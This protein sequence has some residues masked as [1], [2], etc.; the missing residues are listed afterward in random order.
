MKKL[1]LAALA[2]TLGFASCSKDS[3]GDQPKGDEYASVAFTFTNSMTRGGFDQIDPGEAENGVN[4]SILAITGR[5]HVFI[6]KQGN[7]LVKESLDLSNASDFNSN[8]TRPFTHKTGGSTDADRLKNDIDQVILVGNAPSGFAAAYA[9]ATTV[10][11]L[12]AIV[13]ELSAA[14]TSYEGQSMWV[15]GET[16]TINE[17]STS[18]NGNVT[19]TNMEASINLH[20]VLSRL[21]VTV[22][23]GAVT[24]GIYASPAALLTARE[25]LS[26]DDRTKGGVVVQSVSVVYSAKGFSL[27]EPFVTQP[28]AS[29]QSSPVLT[30]GLN[31]ANYSNWT[32]GSHGYTTAYGNE[33][34]EN[35]LFADWNGTTW[36]NNATN[37]NIGN[38]NGTTTNYA[39]NVDGNAFQTGT[40]K[41]TFYAF[42]PKNYTAS[43]FLGNTSYKPYTILSIHVKEYKVTDNGGTLEADTGVDRFFSMKFDST[44]GGANSQ[45]LIPGNRYLVSLTMTGDFSNGGGGGKTPEDDG[46]ANLVVKVTPAQWKAVISVSKDFGPTP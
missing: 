9:S 7:L 17:V 6:A 20:P 26:G 34:A 13:Y 16:K 21:D 14:E 43:T 5:L 44:D 46:F 19:V 31:V 40:F 32:A 39:E 37:P 35:F 22:G 4:Q 38:V 18:T 10:A 12:N 33:T 8:E 29:T 36:V 1:I 15:Q 41:R 28:T 45:E 23:L 3:G 30:S 11:Q 2:V 24:D 42:S 25:A 27:V